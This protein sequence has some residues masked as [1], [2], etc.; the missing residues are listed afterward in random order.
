ML[1][2][3]IAGLIAQGMEVFDAAVLGVHVHGAAADAWAERH[4][5]AGLL[6][7][8]LADGVPAVLKH[9]RG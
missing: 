8:E 2:G 5:T 3:L 1:T 6:A 4:G 9:L 7:S